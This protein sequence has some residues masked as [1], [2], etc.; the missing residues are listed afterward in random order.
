MIRRIKA[1]TFFP[2]GNPNNKNEIDVI[3]EV[4]PKTLALGRIPL[5]FVFW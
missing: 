5:G 2:Q 3:K 1:R 4:E